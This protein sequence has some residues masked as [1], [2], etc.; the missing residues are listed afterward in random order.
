[1]L[2]SVSISGRLASIYGK[3]LQCPYV[4]T[5]NGKAAHF[6]K[7]ELIW[8]GGLCRLLGILQFIFVLSI[9]PITEGL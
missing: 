7:R 8:D 4:V 2:F 1:M 9:H 3:S 5:I 6:P